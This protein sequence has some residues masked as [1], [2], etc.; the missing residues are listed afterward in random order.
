MSSSS[1]SSSLTAATTDSADAATE[2]ESIA[3]DEAVVEYEGSFSRPIKLL[4]RVSVFT[5]GCTLLTIPALVFGGNEGMELAQRIAVSGTVSTFALGTTA[6]LHLFTRS[7]VHR[8]VTRP[9][10]ALDIETLTFFA[11]P[12]TTTVEG[13][14]E[15]VGAPKDSAMNTFRIKSTG[16]QFFAHG[17]DSHE[18][19][20]TAFFDKFIEKITKKD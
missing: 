17:D 20:S 8:M 5:C 12:K 13:G 4:K 3:A 9:S 6:A 15:D 18:F 11:L 7:Y 2:K 14:I 19:R 1:S 10:G 16:A